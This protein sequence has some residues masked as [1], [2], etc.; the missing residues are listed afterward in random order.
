MT[1]K[2]FEHDDPILKNMLDST[3]EWAT[4]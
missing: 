2:R 3:S 4:S 1:G